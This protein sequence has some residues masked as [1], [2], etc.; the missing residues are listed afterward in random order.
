MACRLCRQGVPRKIDLAYGAIHATREQ[1]ERSVPA[2]KPGEGIVFENARW[3]F[4]PFEYCE[5][6]PES[7]CTGA[8]GEPGEAD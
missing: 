6:N 1:V 5:D 3:T 2:R 4:F 8:S 7:R